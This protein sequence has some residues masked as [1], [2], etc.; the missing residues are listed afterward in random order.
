[1]ST[2]ALFLSDRCDFT[3][4]HCG[5]AM[6][7]GHSRSTWQGEYP[8][9]TQTVENEYRCARCGATLGLKLVEPDQP[10]T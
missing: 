2:F 1:V 8:E 5:E 7:Y 3:L 10:A 4:L 6:T 9:G